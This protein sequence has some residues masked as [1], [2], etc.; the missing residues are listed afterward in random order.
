MRSINRRE[1]VRGPIRRSYREDYEALRAAV[2][3]AVI[4]LNDAADNMDPTL[5]ESLTLGSIRL[6]V[7]KRAGIA[8]GLRLAT[9]Y[10]TDE[11]LGSESSEDDGED[12]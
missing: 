3:G 7:T 2:E 4:A 6:E 10:L 5:E 8:R 1:H 12:A 11:V 9:G